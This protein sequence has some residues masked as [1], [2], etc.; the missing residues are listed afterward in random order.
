MVIWPEKVSCDDAAWQSACAL[1]M[2]LALDPRQSR[3]RTRK[4]GEYFETADDFLIRPLIWVDKKQELAP[5]LS[6]S[7]RFNVSCSVHGYIPIDAADQIKE[8][9][10]RVNAALQSPLTVAER[11]R[12]ACNTEFIACLRH[13][14]PMA[15]TFAATGRDEGQI[16]DRHYLNVRNSIMESRRSSGYQGASLCSHEEVIDGLVVLGATLMHA[17]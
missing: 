16:A 3:S 5:Y 13:K 7:L 12:W 14:D 11:K 8:F 10:E 17:V 4:T 9:K 6:Y 15:D 1:M 2:V